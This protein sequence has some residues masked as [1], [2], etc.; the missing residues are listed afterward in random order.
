MSV[1]P[2]ADV[3]LVFP[4]ARAPLG[5]QRQL[6]HHPVLLVAVLGHVVPQLAHVTVVVAAVHH[7]GPG[8]R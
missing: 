6:H 2:H 1:N 8:L 5:P 3:S 7:H 4:P